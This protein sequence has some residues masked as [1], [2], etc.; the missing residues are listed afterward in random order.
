MSYTKP[1]AET[2]VRA[3]NLLDNEDFVVIM[4]ERAAY[5]AENVLNEL[6]EK[7]ILKARADYDALKDLNDWL[8]F[9]AKTGT[10]ARP[11]VVD[12]EDN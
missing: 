6:E 1:N 8:K 10:I 3:K 7:D 11:P 9:V 12:E 2:A 5:L 4:N